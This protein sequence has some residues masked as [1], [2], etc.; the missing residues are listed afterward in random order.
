[1]A[2]LSRLDVFK[3]I[4]KRTTFR[5][6]AISKFGLNEAQ[7]TENQIFNSLCGI[8]VIF[9]IMAISLVF[10]YFLLV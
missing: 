7:V 3:L 8:L 10:V 1:M 2:D 4:L 6:V 9:L 5:E